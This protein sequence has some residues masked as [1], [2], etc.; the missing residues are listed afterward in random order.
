MYF[1]VKKQSVPNGNAR[2]RVKSKYLD[3]KAEFDI[4]N[5][6]PIFT[7]IT[8]SKDFVITE[9]SLSHKVEHICVT[10]PLKNSRLHHDSFVELSLTR[11]APKKGVEYGK[12]IYLAAA[13]F[14]YTAK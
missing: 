6:K 13:V 14:R 11:I 10:I 4:F 5:A 1:L 7:C 2:I 9:P 8:D 3:N 12:D